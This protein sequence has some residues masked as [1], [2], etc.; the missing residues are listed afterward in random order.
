MRETDAVIADR[1]RK[2]NDALQAAE[3]AARAEEQAAEQAARAAEQAAR[4]AEKD[5][6]ENERRRKTQQWNSLLSFGTGAGVCVSSI[7]GGLALGGPPGGAVGGLVG[8]V[9]LEVTSAVHSIDID[10]AQVKKDLLAA[11]SY[12]WNF[13]YTKTA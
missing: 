10:L 5:E 12:I 1:I 3:Q 4:A 7:G 13:N 8:C 9:P 2:I 6:R 11:L